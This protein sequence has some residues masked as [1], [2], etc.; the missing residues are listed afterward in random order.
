MKIV[1]IL[2]ALLV[3]CG[4]VYFFAEDNYQDPGQTRT[5]AYQLPP[6]QKHPAHRKALLASRYQSLEELQTAIEIDYHRDPSEAP[7]AGEYTAVY[8]RQCCEGIEV[9]GVLESGLSQNQIMSVR[10]KGWLAKAG[11]VLQAPFAASNRRNLIKIF[12]LARRKPM[13]FGVGDVAF[14]D[15]AETSVDHIITHELAYLSPRD[16]SEKG[17]INSFNHIAAQAF[18]TSCFSEEMADYVSDV[19]E[20]NNMEELTSGRFSPEQLVDPLNNPVDNYV[21]LINN[22]WGQEIGKTL[23][24]KYRIHQATYWT[25]QLLADYLNDLQDFYSWAFQIG[26]KPYSVDDELVI[27]F[28]NKINTVMEE[29]VPM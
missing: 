15:L 17:Y 10:A 1:P 25:P 29:K 23:K 4:T 3:L 22:E 20:R 18:I 26:F 27:R 19:H 13:T 9:N 2:I 6:A 12:N 21:D 16:S 5:C 24:E 11:L 14:Y 7:Q 8:L 28:A